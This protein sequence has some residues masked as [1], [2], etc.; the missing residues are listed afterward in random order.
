MAANE[1]QWVYFQYWDPG[2][3]ETP[4]IN[5]HFPVLD[6]PCVVE[7][8]FYA[9]DSDIPDTELQFAECNPLKPLEST[10][11]ISQMPRVSLETGYVS[12]QVH[13]KDG[14]VTE[15]KRYPV[16]Y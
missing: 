8:A 9:I 16:K 2:D 3:D 10:R 12:L 5:V 4:Y 11:G 14:E 6:Y 1:R 7:K 15:V 13:Y